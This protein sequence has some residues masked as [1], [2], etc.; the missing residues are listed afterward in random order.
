MAEQTSWACLCTAAAAIF[1]LLQKW[2]LMGRDQSTRGG[3]GLP[4][5]HRETRQN[6]RL[7]VEILAAVNNQ[8]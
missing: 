1:P 4:I 8:N 6:L 3:P 5:L 7:F 2:N